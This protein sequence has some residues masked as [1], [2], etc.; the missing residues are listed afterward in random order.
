MTSLYRRGLKPLLLALFFLTMVAGL[1][2]ELMSPSL[3]ARGG[4]ASPPTPKVSNDPKI[5]QQDWYGI[6]QW[7]TIGDSYATGVGVGNSLAWNRCVRFSDAYPLLMNKDDRMPGGDPDRK[8]WNCACSGATSQDILDWQFLDN[9][10]L[11][12]NF[13]YGPREIYGR[14]QITT[15]TAGG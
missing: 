1:P 12:P 3:E 2:A 14:P 11:W 15:L 6:V 5:N 9:P 13:P 4:T 8:L 7:T 10:I